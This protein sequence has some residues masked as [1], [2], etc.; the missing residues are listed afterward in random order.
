MLWQWWSDEIEIIHIVRI[1][2][3][4]ACLRPVVAV[5]EIHCWKVLI[6]EQNSIKRKKNLTG[7][8]E[9]EVKF[10]VLCPEHFRVVFK[11]IQA[12][13]EVWGGVVPVVAKSR[14]HL[15]KVTTPTLI[16]NNNINSFKKNCTDT[17]IFYSTLHFH[18]NGMDLARLVKWYWCMEECCN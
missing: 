14:G 10:A 4:V 11:I 6:L 2:Q 16:L 5:R 12:R 17:N 8:A 1:L 15:G 18:Q 13:K 9:L 3:R 7:I